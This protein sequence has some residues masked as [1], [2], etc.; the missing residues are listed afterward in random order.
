M[1]KGMCRKYVMVDMF[2][3]NALNNM[4]LR[5]APDILNTELQ[6]SQKQSKTALSVGLETIELS[7]LIIGMDLQ[8]DVLAS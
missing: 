6:L 5:H 1:E 7:D 4:D 3:Y 2:R 8:R